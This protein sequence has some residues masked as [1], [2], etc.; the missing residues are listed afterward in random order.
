MKLVVLPKQ[1]CESSVLQHFKRSGV[2]LA[3][4]YMLTSQLPLQAE[5]SPQRKVN[6]NC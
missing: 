6:V 3:R 4:E 2:I 5:T 1:Y